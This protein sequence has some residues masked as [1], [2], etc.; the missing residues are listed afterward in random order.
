MY[1]AGGEEAVTM[2]AGKSRLGCCN[3]LSRSPCQSSRSAVAYG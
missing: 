2:M 3:I 1:A